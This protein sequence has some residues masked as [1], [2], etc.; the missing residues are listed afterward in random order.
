MEKS[1]YSREYQVMLR[2]LREARSD[3]GITQVDLAKRLRLTQSLVSKIERGDRRL[4]LAE[5]RSFCRVIGIG[6]VEFVGRVERELA[7]RS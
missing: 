2:L 3:A 6:L 1:I 7:K 4:D 5:L